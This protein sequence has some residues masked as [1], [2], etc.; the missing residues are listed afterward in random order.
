MLKRWVFSSNYK[1]SNPTASWQLTSTRPASRGR[2]RTARARR[3]IC[4][5]RLTGWATRPK[6]CVIGAWQWSCNRENPINLGLL[7]RH[8]YPKKPNESTISHT[9]SLSFDYSC[10]YYNTLQLKQSWSI[11]TCH[12]LHPSSCIDNLHFGNRLF[13]QIIVKN[14]SV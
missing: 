3:C 9:P 2:Q 1:L 13:K 10:H 8:I 12:L 5:S 7:P 14:L 4:E 6:P 11:I